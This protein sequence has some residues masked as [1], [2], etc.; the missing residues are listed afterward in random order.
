MTNQITDLGTSFYQQSCQLCHGGRYLLQ[1][2][3]L[4]VFA[5]DTV[6]N[7]YLILDISAYLLEWVAASIWLPTMQFVL[8]VPM[9]RFNKFGSNC[10][11]KNL[12]ILK[13]TE[14][15]K[16][17]MIFMSKKISS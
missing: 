11:E 16:K 17:N 13:Q 15:H 14:N 2:K 12:G 1:S 4:L 10:V 9:T 6:S 5:Q 7:N 3:R 8:H